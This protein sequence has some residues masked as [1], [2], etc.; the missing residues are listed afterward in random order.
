M[1]QTGEFV[2]M[3]TIALIIN[4]K[5]NKMEIL[6]DNQLISIFVNGLYFVFFVPCTSMHIMYNISAHVCL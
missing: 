5:N 1:P 2:T 4:K 3:E 6:K